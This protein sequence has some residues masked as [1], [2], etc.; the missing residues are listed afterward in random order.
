MES[1]WSQTDKYGQGLMQV[2]KT[3]FAPRFGFA[4]QINPKL[5]VRGGFGFF[6]NCI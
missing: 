3:N 2:Q 6:Y 1:S 5:V 4:Y